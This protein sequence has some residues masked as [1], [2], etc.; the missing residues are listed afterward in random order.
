MSHGYVVLCVPCKE[1]LPVGKMV[2]M[3]EDGREVQWQFGGRGNDP[4]YPH[5]AGILPAIERFLIVHRG[6]R[7]HVAPDDFVSGIVDDP[8][9]PETGW[10]TVELLRDL[11]DRKVRPEPDIDDDARR[12]PTDLLDD[13]RRPWE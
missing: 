1:L 9:L 7:L 8:E 6:H 10:R 4:D 12:L 2:N 3:D 5:R 13:L 11:L